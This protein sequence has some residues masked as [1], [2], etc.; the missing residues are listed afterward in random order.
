MRRSAL[1]VLVAIAALLAISACHHGD[2]APAASDSSSSAPA[3]SS[4]A[5]SSSSSADDPIGV[6]ECDD[7][8]RA[9]R[10]CVQNKVPEG[11]RADLNQAIDQSVALWRQAAA[12]P[13]GKA[14]LGAACTTARDAMKSAMS[15]YGCSL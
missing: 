9:Y 5:S 4:S 3:T 8:L 1:L 13:E 10:D 11:S 12:T 7:Y 14:G 15:Q 6:P 2:S